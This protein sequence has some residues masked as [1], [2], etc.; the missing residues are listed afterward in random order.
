MSLPARMSGLVETALRTNYPQKFDRLRENEANSVHVEICRWVTQKGRSFLR[1][2]FDFL[3]CWDL[4][5]FSVRSV[6]IRQDTCGSCEPLTPACEH[7]RQG[8][9]RCS[10][11]RSSILTMNKMSSAR[12][13]TPRRP[14]ALHLVKERHSQLESL[15]LQSRNFGCRNVSVSVRVSHLA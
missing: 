4:R 3:P 2:F 14:A 6:R 10:D 9:A 12:S 13:I 15:R 1:P 11:P 7:P 5:Q 8:P